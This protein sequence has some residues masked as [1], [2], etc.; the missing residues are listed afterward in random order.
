[1]TLKLYADRMELS[2]LQ[3]G[4][5]VAKTITQYPQQPYSSV[6]LLIYDIELATDCLQQAIDKYQ[7]GKRPNIKLIIQPQDYVESGLCDSEVRILK[8][9]GKQANCSM[10]EIEAPL[11][12][13]NP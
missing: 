8:W 4:S 7:L 13:I 9:L 12:T 2:G 3:S 11:A 10:V 5:S 1:M 6:R